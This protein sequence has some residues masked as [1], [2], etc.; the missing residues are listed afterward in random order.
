MDS[1][2]QLAP[3]EPQRSGPMT[4]SPSP[5]PESGANPAIHHIE[6]LLG[7]AMQQG[8]V[9]VVSGANCQPFPVASRTVAEARA[10][11]EYIMNIDPTAT[12]LVN[13]AV[14]PAEHVLQHSDM[15]EF[16]KEG[17]EKGASSAEY[18]NRRQACENQIG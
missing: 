6:E 10:S 3:Q 13:G 17:G 8:E 2:E 9:L 12:A 11:L 14:V 5:E 7:G 15:L 18:R 16:T 4:G 1:R